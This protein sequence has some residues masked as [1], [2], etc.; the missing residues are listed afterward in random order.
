MGLFNRGKLIDPESGYE[1][2]PKTGNSW[3]DDRRE[4][5]S[6]RTRVKVAELAL[7]RATNPEVMDRGRRSDIYRKAFQLED[8][9]RSAKHLADILETRLEASEER[10]RML[11][12]VKDLWMR[13]ALDAENKMEGK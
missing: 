2:P 4:I 8:E 11:A 3:D 1:H 6:L 13:R 10:C 12:E 7:V 5:E 9:S